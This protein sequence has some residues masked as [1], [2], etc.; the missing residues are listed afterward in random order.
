MAEARGGPDAT[1]ELLMSLRQW[2]KKQPPQVRELAVIVAGNL[3][4]GVRS[5][6]TDSPKWRAM[7][8]DQ[9]RRLEASVDDKYRRSG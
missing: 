9:I 2:R 5:G 8:A 7:M 3:A 1:A 4:I 6:C